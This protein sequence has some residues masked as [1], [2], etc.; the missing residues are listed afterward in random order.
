MRKAIAKSL[1]QSK[2]SIP[3]FYIRLT[4][5]ARPMLDFYRAQK[6]KF[7]CSIN[8]VIV[9]TCSR[10]LK[11]FPAFRSRVEGEEI[12]ESPSVNIGLA[13]G[14]DESLVVPVLQQADGM[15]LA[16]IAAETKRLAASA[17]NGKIVAMGSG[18]FTI[19]NLGMFG[20]GG[21]R[22]YH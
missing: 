14:I 9:M 12:V 15:N 21:I 4:I 20:T 1:V 16:E 17:R 3:H 8:D 18:S 11:E 22:R 5:D 19:T 2:Q 6:E 13:V 7:P 10:L